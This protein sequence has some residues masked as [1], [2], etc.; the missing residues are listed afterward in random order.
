MA[1]AS[2]RSGWPPDS[3]PPEVQF[4]LEWNP[5][6]MIIGE[7]ADVDMATQGP[8]DTAMKTTIGSSRKAAFYDRHLASHL[9]LERVVHLDDLVSVVAG[10]VD[11]AIH[12]AI[13]KQPLPKKSGILLPTEVIEFQV[14]SS[15]WTKYHESGVA[16]AYKEHT[17]TYCLP[18][19]STLV[20][21]PSSETWNRALIWT[22]DRKSEKWA[23]ADAVLRMSINI[24]QD[25]HPAQK[26]LKN[27][28]DR[29]RALLKQLASRST[30][31]AVWE[32]KSLTVGTAE[33]M[34][35]IVEMGLTGSKF[36]WAKCTAR[37]CAHERLE[38]MPES[39]ESYDEGVDPL[40]PPW[41]LPTDPIPPFSSSRPPTLREGLRRA[42][43]PGSAG[44]ANA[45]PLYAESSMSSF[46]SEVVGEKRPHDGSDGS[47][48]EQRPSKKSKSKLMDKRDKDYEPR[49]GDRQEVTA[50]SFL[51]QVTAVIC[52]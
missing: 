49:P 39:G 34:A 51:Q 29:K 40:S 11:Q 20:I 47:A 3:I 44:G 36:R 14:E 24:S 12:D 17:T 5:P 27:E 28:D 46:D 9:I 19:A 52:P 15:V 18:I 48:Y 25:D 22:V 4:V 33:V 2:S 37:V 30:T 35:E 8:L 38:Y 31:L 45:R 26:L 50:Q 41:T 32:M 23:V 10:T 16:E 7:S 42:S 6:R 13:T 21:H 43:A 1:S